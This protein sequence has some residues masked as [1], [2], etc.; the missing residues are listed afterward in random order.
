MVVNLIFAINT[1]MFRYLAWPVFR[2]RRASCFACRQ[3]HLGARVH[4]V[5]VTRHAFTI[6]AVAL[7][8]AT[9]CE[10]TSRSCFLQPA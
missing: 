6:Q 10:A 8:A 9:C 2:A 5:Q 4:V 7:S 3:P 1:H